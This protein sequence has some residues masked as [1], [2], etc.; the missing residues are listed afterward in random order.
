MA[1]TLEN[2]G[3]RWLLTK[4]VNFVPWCDAGSEN[5]TRFT[6]VGGEYCH[7]CAIPDSPS[8]EQPPENLLL[9]YSLHSP[10]L[11][12]MMQF[13]SQQL[14]LTLMLTRY[15]FVHINDSK[16]NRRAVQLHFTKA[17][18]TWSTSP[19]SI[20]LDFLCPTV[21]G[22]RHNESLWFFGLPPRNNV[23]PPRTKPKGTALHLLRK[24]KYIYWHFTG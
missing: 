21:A 14:V 18:R 13:I 23:L 3:A 6:L 7:L 1:T 9:P 20:W 11:S 12:D 4:K 8:R 17:Y 2:L 16:P 5:Q 15:I 22:C 19:W 24:K 10:Y